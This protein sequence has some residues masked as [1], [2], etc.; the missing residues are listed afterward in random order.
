AMPHSNIAIFV[1]HIGCPNMCSFCNQHSISGKENPPTSLEVKAICE[2]A[3]LEISDK[4]NTEI[5]FFGGS[6]T[7]IPRDYMIELLE[8]ANKFV[9]EEKFFGIRISTR[10]DCI[11]AEILDILKAYGVTSI[12]LGAQ[13]MCDEVLAANNRGH[14][15]DDVRNASALIREKGFELGLQMMVGLYKSSVKLDRFTAGEIAKLRPKTVRIYPTA[16]LEDTRLAELYKSGEYQPYDF[17]DA[18][19]LCA[20]LL[21]FFQNENIEIIRLGLHASDMISANLVGGFYHPAFKELCENEIFRHR[22][23]DEICGEKGEFI[24]EVAQK[25][26]SKAIG[27]NKSNIEFFAK[28]GIKIVVKSSQELTKYN[29]KVRRCGHNC[30]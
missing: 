2:Q 12:E 15:S 24:V 23:S 11:N 19:A 5:A 18:V 21:L 28:K 1:P 13:S 16:I 22:I 4:E 27:Q 9:G 7:A 14:S 29:I 8:T 26:I 3:L 20:E 17:S 30:T 10:P 25:S 6:F